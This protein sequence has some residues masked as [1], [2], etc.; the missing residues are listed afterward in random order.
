MKI[1]T[2]L[3]IIIIFTHSIANASV[4]AK[5][6]QTINKTSFKKL[7]DS[8]N[9]LEIRDAVYSELTRGHIQTASEFICMRREKRWK[10]VWYLG[11]KEGEL[12]D[13][14]SDPDEL[15]N[16]WNSEKYSTIRRDQET[17]IQEEMIRNMV[18]AQSRS[19]EKP[20]PYM[21]IK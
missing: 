14:L 10:L 21:E 4:I 9:P 18:Q 3:F 13:L 12:Y 8:E 20:Q 5:K 11:E 6:L 16:L 7:L 15:V 1:L 17:L 19:M 2:S